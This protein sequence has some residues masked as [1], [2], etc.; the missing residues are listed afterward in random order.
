[1]ALNRV[2]SVDGVCAACR[3]GEVQFGTEDL[4]GVVKSNILMVEMARSSRPEKK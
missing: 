3:P 4:E 2:C 1:V